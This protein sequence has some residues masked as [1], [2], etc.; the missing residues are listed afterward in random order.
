MSEDRTLSDADVKAVADQLYARIVGDFYRDLGKGVFGY[1][2]K[3]VIVILL[4]IAAY[5][6]AKYSGSVK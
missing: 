1:V 4:A 6:A 3:V 5:G 2:K